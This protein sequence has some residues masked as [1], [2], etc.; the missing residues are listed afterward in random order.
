MNV[1]SAALL[2]LAL[3]GGLDALYFVLVTYRWLRPD[4]P[5]LPRI[6]RMDEGTCARIV[7]TREARA[8]GVPNA[9]LGLAWYV[10]LGAA[11]V[12][13]LPPAWQVPLLGGAAVAFAMSLGLAWALLARLQVRCTLCFAVHAINVAVL[14]LLVLP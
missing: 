6:C 1:S 3:I 5:W 4:A 2:A 14:A 12:L 13:G 7:D 9:V 11:T 10:V 8:L